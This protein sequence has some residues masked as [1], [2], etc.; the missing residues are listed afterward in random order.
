METPGTIL[1]E[2]LR[3]IIFNFRTRM[4]KIVFFIGIRKRLHT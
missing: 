2:N 4:L 1:I 3:C